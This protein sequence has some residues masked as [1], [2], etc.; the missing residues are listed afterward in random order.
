MTI[1]CQLNTATSLNFDWF[2]DVPQIISIFRSNITGLQNVCVFSTSN[3]VLKAEMLPAE[4]F[5]SETYT[6][7]SVIYYQPKELTP[8]NFYICKKSGVRN[9]TC[10]IQYKN[11]TFAGDHTN[12]KS[13]DDY[14]KVTGAITAE[15]MDKYECFVNMDGIFHLF[16]VVPK[17]NI[18]E[19]QEAS[20]LGTRL[21]HESNCVDVSPG[22]RCSTDDYL[23]LETCKAKPDWFCPHTATYDFMSNDNCQINKC[24]EAANQGVQLC[25][26]GFDDCVHINMTYHCRRGVP[27]LDI[28]NSVSRDLNLS[29]PEL[30]R[31]TPNLELYGNTLHRITN[32]AKVLNQ[33]NPNYFLRL[34]SNLSNE[35]ILQELPL[36]SDYEKQLMASRLLDALV[37]A[38]EP[39]KVILDKHLPVS[40]AP[41]TSIPST[42]TPDGTVILGDISV[43]ETSTPSHTPPQK[44]KS[45]SLTEKAKTATMKVKSAAAVLHIIATIARHSV[46]VRNMLDTGSADRKGF[47]FLRISAKDE[48]AKVNSSFGTSMGLM[49]LADKGTSDSDS[50]VAT[51]PAANINAHQETELLSVKKG[52]EDV[53]RP[54]VNSDVVLIDTMKGNST[55]K[56]TMNLVKKPENYLMCQQLHQD[57]DTFSS[58]WSADDCQTIV[59]GLQYECRCTPRQRGTFAIALVYWIGGS[60][61]PTENLFMINLV[62]Y[63]FTIITIVALFLFLI[64]TRFIGVFRLDQ[65]NIAFC[66]MLSAIVSLAIPHVTDQQP[67][68]C[69]MVAIAV[70]FFPLAAFSWKFIFGL[71][72][73]ILIVAP[74]WRYHDLISKQHHCIPLVWIGY[75]IPAVIVGAWFGY[76]EKVNLGKHCIGPANLR[77]AFIGP[78]TAV[79]IFNFIVLIVVG[80]ILLR[81]Y[82]LTRKSRLN[83]ST[84]LLV[85]TQL[86]LTLGIPYIAIYI[87]FLDGIS[88]FIIV[89]V[90]MALTSVLMFLLVAVIDEENRH[91]FR[92]FLRDHFI[93]PSSSSTQTFSF[94][95][96]NGTAT[97]DSG[98]GNYNPAKI[99]NTLHGRRWSCRARI[100]GEHM[101]DDCAKRLNHDNVD[102]HPL[103]DG[104]MSSE[105]KTNPKTFTP[106]WL[107]QTSTGPKSSTGDS[108]VLSEDSLSA[109]AFRRL[110]TS[111]ASAGDTGTEPPTPTHAKGGL[112][113]NSTLN[114]RTSQIA[115]SENENIFASKL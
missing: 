32:N 89:P 34:A 40:D 108:I 50:I 110:A 23:D 101:N 22:Y 52:F 75:L 28:C 81:S 105:I 44:V 67:V 41:L 60:V 7:S 106:G 83:K 76:A 79:V 66:L 64:F 70:C 30:T 55:Y 31:D 65:F 72:T 91:R 95:Q 15:H 77:W 90:A 27:L 111:A 1:G 84:H 10:L 48:E 100:V 39:E 97:G 38:L 8:I 98:N 17:S 54:V 42:N 5:D 6:H 58:D 33:F 21:C 86:M 12:V 13:D 62:N 112:D 61:I 114:A 93:Q 11:G 53:E 74:H 3:G 113:S 80:I 87:Q 16:S 107:H 102:G 71:N 49:I 63:L 82:L 92:V 78:I 85:L 73:L 43:T 35:K 51:V 18:N 20:D 96:K 57:R 19:C 88:M 4:K 68:P 103:E 99:G 109:V 46:G 24:V 45:V 47:K 9:G 2:P 37:S 94:R 26:V 56:L 14:Y 104:E 59:V 29:C 69:T 115:P 36:Y 25:D